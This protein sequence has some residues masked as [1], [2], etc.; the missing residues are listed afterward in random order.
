[1]RDVVSTVVDRPPAD[2]FRFVGHE[3]FANHPRWDENVLEMTPLE[4]GPIA[5]GSKARVRRKRASEDEILEVL[6]FEPDRRWR[7]RDN[8][9]PFLL[10]MT[11]VIDP[12]GDNASRLTLEADVLASG[13]AR[14][15]ARVL[16]P[17]FRRQMRKSLAR[18]KA[19]IEGS[20]PPGR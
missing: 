17:V 6:D 7:S 2:V 14:V 18:I 8:V 10:T 11:A 1:M 19:M 13:P 9:G 12:V 16:R 3:H 15:A 20:T 4:P 5:A